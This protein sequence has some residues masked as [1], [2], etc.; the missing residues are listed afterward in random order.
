MAKE[1]LGGPAQLS[2]PRPQQNPLHTAP[3]SLAGPR[4]STGQPG[5]LEVHA[6]VPTTIPEQQEFRLPAAGLPPPLSVFL[7]S[8][9]YEGSSL[10]LWS[11]PT[12]PLGPALSPGHWNPVYQDLRRRCC[13][14]S[15]V[16]GSCGGQC[17]RGA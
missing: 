13:S 14:P 5:G 12:S 3:S 2:P 9:S 1:G 7:P 16:A 6:H 11:C 17:K 8:G 15:L 10:S 4:L